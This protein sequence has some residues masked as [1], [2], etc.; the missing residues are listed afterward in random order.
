MRVRETSSRPSVLNSANATSVIGRRLNR[1]S[2][3]CNQTLTIA[4][5]IGREFETRQLARL[6]HDNSVD[7]GQRMSEDRLLDVL[8]G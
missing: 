5:V 7:S 1:L 3:R 2:E 8:G 6:V 4:A